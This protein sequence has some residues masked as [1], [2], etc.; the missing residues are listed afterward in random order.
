MP[1]RFTTFRVEASL[2]RVLRISNISCEII[3]VNTKVV[4][5]DKNFYHFYRFVLQFA[6]NGCIVI[7]IR[8]EHKRAH[9]E[10]K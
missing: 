2:F 5:F 10:H 3:K 7:G 1:C 6:K 4:R 8:G 9:R